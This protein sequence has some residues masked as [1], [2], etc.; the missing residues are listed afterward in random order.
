MKWLTKVLIGV[1]LLLAVVG[2]GYAA[3]GYQ[4]L[5]G[6]TQRIDEWSVC[7]NVTN[8]SGAHL[9]V[10]TNSSGEWAS[11]RSYPPGGVGLGYCCGSCNVTDCGV[12]GCAAY[13][14][15]SNCMWCNTCYVANNCSYCGYYH[16]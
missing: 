5:N 12:C 10:P 16:Q 13:D 7:R 3:S 2:V 6:T 11:F 15:Y 8:S 9:F 14:K 1:G 4:V